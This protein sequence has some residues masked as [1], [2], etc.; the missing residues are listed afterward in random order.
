MRGDVRHRNLCLR[1]RRA[2]IKNS[3]A[4]K[5]PAKASPSRFST[6]EHADSLQ[7]LQLAICFTRGV[8]LS[9]HSLRVGTANTRAVERLPATVRGTDGELFFELGAF[10]P[11]VIGIQVRATVSRSMRRWRV[12]LIEDEERVYEL[13]TAGAPRTARRR[14][15]WT[16]R[17]LHTI[18]VP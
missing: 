17:W 15:V 7:R 12:F 10:R 2:G 6:L 4:V 1:V 9:V 5:R 18:Q 16:G 11:G 14:D 3:A 13:R 8:A